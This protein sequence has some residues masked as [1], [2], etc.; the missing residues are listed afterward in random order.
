M[1]FQKQLDRL[2]SEVFFNRPQRRQAFLMTDSKGRYL[3]AQV[4]RGEAIV[5]IV[6]KSG[7]RVDNKELL[8]IIS[9]KIMNLDRPVVLVWLGTCEFTEKR[10]RNIYLREQNSVADV[11]AR[12][13]AL[14]ANIIKQNSSTEVIFLKCPIYSIIHENDR[15]S[16][17]SE[18]EQLHEKLEILNQDI[19]HL[20]ATTVPNLSMDLLK[21][22]KRKQGCR[23]NCVYKFQDLYKDGVHPIDILAELWLRKIQKIVCNICF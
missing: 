14:K 1:I 2:E 7:A 20:N 5:D 23:S 6:W 22:T 19:S 11:L 21:N 8:S 3:E 10:G 18:D 12:L 16:F 17:S 4:H 15:D 13:Q 9:D